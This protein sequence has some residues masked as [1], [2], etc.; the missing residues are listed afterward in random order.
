[1][2]RFIQHSFLKPEKVEEY[3]E[4]HANAWPGVLETIK[5]CNIQHYSISISGNELYSY[6]EYV[7]DDYDA[8]MELMAQDPVT[9]E[10]GSIQDPA[11]STMTRAY[12]MTI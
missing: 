2:Q 9:Q 4:L 11:S 12:T 7:G 1:M 8:D 10:C 3:C 5:K 6:F